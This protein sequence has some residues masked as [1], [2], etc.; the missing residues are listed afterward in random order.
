MDDLL[1]FCRE[2]KKAKVNTMQQ[3]VEQLKEQA[4][5]LA[6]LQVMLAFLGPLFVQGQQ[7]MLTA[8]L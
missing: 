7:A 3:T 8:Q 4:A 1:F 6:M 2:R 5:E